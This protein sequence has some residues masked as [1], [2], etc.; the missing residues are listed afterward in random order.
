MSFL[1][2]DEIQERLKMAEHLVEAAKDRELI[3]I[4]RRA[5]EDELVSF[6]DS[7]IAMLGRGNGLVIR[8]KDG[9]ESAVIRLGLEDC[10][11]IGLKAMALAIRASVE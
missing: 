2:D 10:L 3:E 11:R 7:R 8:E 9:Q 6:R 5:I 1:D 4:G